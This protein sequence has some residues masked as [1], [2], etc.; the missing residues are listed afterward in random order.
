MMDERDVER[1][2][3]LARTELLGGS[4]AGIK[5]QLCDVVRE[6]FKDSNSWYEHIPISV[7]A[8]QRWYR[9]TPAHGGM[10]LRLAAVWDANHIALPSILPRL[11]P[12]SAELELVYPQNNSY[13]AKCIVTKQIAEPITRDML[14]DAPNWLLP[15]YHETILDGVLGKMMGQSNKSYSNDTLSTYHLRRFRDGIMQARVASERANL[16][17]GQAWRFPNSFRTNSQRGGVSTPFP[18]PTSW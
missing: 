15:A 14:P 12:P 8:N 13:T 2:M 10:I 6:F 3:N 1:L 18:A 5:A 11:D 7:I 16:Y 4:D 17:G 9:I